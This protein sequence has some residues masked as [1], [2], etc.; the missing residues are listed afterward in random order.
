VA[1]LRGRGEK[2][3]RSPSTFEG[4]QVLR[5][6]A[7]RTEKM[8]VAAQGYKSDT[9]TQ[10]SNRMG[11]WNKATGS[12]IQY[13]W[14]KGKS[15]KPVDGWKHLGRRRDYRKSVRGKEDWRPGEKKKGVVETLKERA[16]P[17][18]NKI[19]KGGLDQ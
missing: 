19:E 8:S 1:S 6:A 4:G 18:G 7:V 5:V 13:Q 12:T 15:G 11:G 9:S 3:G 2:G 14:L 17:K 10:E 16:G